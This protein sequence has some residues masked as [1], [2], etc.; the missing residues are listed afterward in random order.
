MCGVGKWMACWGKWEANQCTRCGQ[1]EDTQHVLRCTGR[2]SGEVWQKSVD[3]LRKWMEDRQTHL[4]IINIITR[5]LISWRNNSP[6]I[7]LQ[8]HPFRTELE[9]QEGIGWHRLPVGWLGIC[10]TDIKTDYYRTLMVWK[11]GAC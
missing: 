10:W 11:S 2:G 9:I 7:S 8:L 3:S 6:G 5:G 1:P 4:E